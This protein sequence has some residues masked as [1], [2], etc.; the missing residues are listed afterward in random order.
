MTKTERYQLP[1]WEATDPV[2]REDF[3]AAMA[4][5]DGGLA[6]SAYVTGSYVGTGAAIVV[7]LGFRPR[8]LIISGQIGGVA[9]ANSMQYI[10][11]SFGT[12]LSSY[13]NLTDTGF[14]AASKNITSTSSDYPKLNLSVQ[15][16]GYLAF[17]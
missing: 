12:N 7:D 1:Q 11:L 3:N 10:G 4:A 17:R 6:A 9:L 5:I 14:T 2:R 13:V 15:R 8:F 16:Y